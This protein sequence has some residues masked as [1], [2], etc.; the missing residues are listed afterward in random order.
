VQL[1]VV[2]VVVVVVVKEEEV[3]V[4]QPSV[5]GDWQ[6]VVAS[7]LWPAVLLPGG[8]VEQEGLVLQTSEQGYDPCG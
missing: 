6:L 4:E 2:V 5:V 8:V 7:L 3:V 1:Q